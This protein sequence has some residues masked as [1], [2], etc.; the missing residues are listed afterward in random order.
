[1]SEEQQSMSAEQQMT[2]EGYKD[3]SSWNGR[4][5]QTTT[6]FDRLF[7]PVTIGA[8]AVSLVKYDAYFTHVYIGGGLLL[9]FWILLSWRYYRRISDRFL[10]MKEIEY[11]LGF[12]A[13]GRLSDNLGAPKD[14][15]LR[16]WFYIVTMLIGALVVIVTP[17]GLK[18]F[19]NENQRNRIVVSLAFVVIFLLACVVI[20]LIVYLFTRKADSPCDNCCKSDE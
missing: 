20:P 19:I 3:L 12:K 6:A 9:A 11:C 13:H 16:I 10:A 18:N 14:I 8:W 1:M 4:D 2:L 15:S 7:L 17:D 5:K